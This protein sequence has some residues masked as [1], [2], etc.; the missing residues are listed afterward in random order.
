[1]NCI[2]AQSGGPT[3]VI[4]SSLM[5]VLDGALKSGEFDKIFAGFNGIEGILK[6]NIKDISHLSAEKKEIIKHSPAAILGSCR[7]KL[8]GIDENREQYEKL[9]HIFKK[10]DIGAFFYIGGNDSMDTVKNLS[11]YAKENN[12]DFRA[13]GVPKTIDNDLE[14]MDH[15]PGFGSAA[16]FVNTCIMETALDDSVYEGKSLIILE[17]M[18]REAG[19]L[20]ASAAAAKINGET[21]VD[22]I[23]VPEN[24]FS[25]LRFL[26]TIKNDLMK[27][28]KL[29]IVV[30]EGIRYEDGEFVSHSSINS[31]HDTFGHAQ[32]GG[33]GQKL[34]Q[35]LIDSGIIKRVKCVEL[36]ILQRCAAHVS[37]EVDVNEAFEL[38]AN[39]VKF[40]SQGLSGVL[41]GII[42]TCDEPYAYEIKPIEIEKVANHTKLLPKQWIDRENDFIT[43]DMI[44]YVEPLMGGQEAFPVY[45]DN[46]E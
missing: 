46:V 31:G 26:S 38:G 27:K 1:M 34:R 19:W 16:K 21:I 35:M 44:R 43:E 15:T 41:P 42:R 36:N 5:G 24:P 39:A 6:E 2:V 10:Y 33:A 13:V 25:D 14:V 9:F 28:D 22:H 37:S 30:S 29:Y 12:I 8:K 40:A 11:I 20:A 3:A 23:Y 7:F 18:G 17:T 4:N 32:L 45:L